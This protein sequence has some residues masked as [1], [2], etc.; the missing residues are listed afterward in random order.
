LKRCDGKVITSD[1]R[2][3][4][5]DDACENMLLFMPHPRTGAR[6]VSRRDQIEPH[7]IDPNYRGVGAGGMGLDGSER[8][9]ASP[10]PAALRRHEQLGR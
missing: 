7:F 1:R 4:C 5:G 6:P 3:T 8:G 10:L 9:S 2:P